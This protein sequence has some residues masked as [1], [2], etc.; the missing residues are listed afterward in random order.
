M[1][2]CLK[3][4][5]DTKRWLVTLP[6]HDRCLASA[7]L[8]W[9]ANHMSVWNPDLALYQQVHSPDNSGVTIH[10]RRPVDSWYHRNW[11][12]WVVLGVVLFIVIVCA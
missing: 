8:V 3:I 10:L 7:F 12:I 1:N 11:G 5:D 6:P 9:E 4:S 2:P